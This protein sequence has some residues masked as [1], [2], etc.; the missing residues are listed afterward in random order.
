M[1]EALEQ[2]LNMIWMLK[3]DPIPQG[4]MFIMDLTQLAITGKFNRTP[5]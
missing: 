2:T 1:L 4:G 3:V 5:N